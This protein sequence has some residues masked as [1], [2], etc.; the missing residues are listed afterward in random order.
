MKDTRAFLFAAALL[1]FGCGPKRVASPVPP[2]EAALRVMTFN[3]NYGLAG[4]DSTLDAITAADVDVVFLQETTPAWEK[5]IRARLSD[6]F[7]HIEFV[8]CCGAGG[9]GVLS[10]LDVDSRG[11][12]EPPADGWFPAW[13]LVF[14]T[15]LG[16]VQALNV[17]LH[18]PVSDTGSFVSG[19]FSTRR[20]REAEIETYWAALDPEIPTI[21]AGDFNENE[22]GRA[23]S[24]LRSK[25]LE[26][27]LPEFAPSAETWRW[28]TSVGRVSSTLD[29][30]VYD[31]RLEP[32]DARVIEQGRSDHMPVVVTFV[33]ATPAG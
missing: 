10:H 19:Y 29:H 14:Q 30:V 15:A 2:N 18:P 9:L 31:P 3:V 23:V 11:V 7:E 26:S 16:P 24:F 12:L 33:R 1:C 6:R 21:V 4:D 32:V 25:G 20:V 17:H 8:H 28:Q 27:A 22:K 13:H 5:T